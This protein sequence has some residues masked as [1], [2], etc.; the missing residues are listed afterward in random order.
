[1]TSSGSTLLFGAIPASLKPTAVEKRALREFTDLLSEEVADSR[2]FVC[3]LA[4]DAQLKKLN[5]D[6]LGHDY[7]TDVLSFPQNSAHDLG[8]IAISLERAS[9]QAAEYGH[10]WLDEVKIL[11]LHGLLHLTGLDHNNG[12]STMARA[13]KRWRTEFNLPETLIARAKKGAA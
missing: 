11:M 1:M 3:L 10:H 5:A 12:D 7:A 8:E 4:G 6:F 2:P 13:E 9:A